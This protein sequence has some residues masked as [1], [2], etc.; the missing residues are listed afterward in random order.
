MTGNYQHD[1]NMIGFSKGAV[2]NWLCQY[3]GAI[4]EIEEIKTSKI[5]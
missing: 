1:R 3:R 5:I 4:L 2:Y